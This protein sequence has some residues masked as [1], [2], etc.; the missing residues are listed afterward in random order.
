MET[1][2]D[3]TDQ[4]DQ[5]EETSE[6]VEAPITVPRPSPV[7]APYTLQGREISARNAITH[8]L[9]ADNTLILSHEKL[10]D[11]EALQTTWF[12]A[13]NPHDKAEIRLVQLLVNADWFLERANRALA[14]AEAHIYECG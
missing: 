14:H 5:F 8:G 6:P 13:Y 2:L 10:E 1:N 7:G 12:E 4:F 3:P 11:Y 9:C